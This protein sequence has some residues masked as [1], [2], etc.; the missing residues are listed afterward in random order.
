MTI[1]ACF[2]STEGVVLGADSTSTLFVAG[3][4]GQPGSQHHFD[5]AQ[6]VF[7]VGGPGSTVGMALW[8]LGSLGDTSYRTLIAQIA[9]EAG[10]KDLTSLDEVAQLAAALL[11]DCYGQSYG[12]WLA[13][14]RELEAKGN[15]RTEAETSELLSWRQALSGGFCLGGRWGSNR[16][17][18]AFEVSFG[19][20]M[21][22]P[23]KPKELTLHSPSFW[24]CPN[25]ISRLIRGMDRDTFVQIMTSGKWNG[26]TDD[27]LAILEHGALGQPSDLPLREAIDWIYA[28]IYT[29]IKAMKFSHLAPV[30]GGPIEIAVICS[31]RPF[32]WVRHK[33][34]GEA[35]AAHQFQE[36][37][38]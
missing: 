33:R 4:G 24:G 20:L 9:D 26:T 37:W 12:G 17:P 8:G 32:R 18:R 10:K 11:W 14:A 29:T 38:V 25:L 1:A 16:Q 19:P 2:L 5:Y 34:L 36:D 27:L 7:E 15:S 13:R 35:I 23:P 28:S 3:R 21:A 31:D 6:K 30:C 22:D